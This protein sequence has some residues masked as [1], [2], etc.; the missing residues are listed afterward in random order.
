MAMFGKPLFI[1]FDNHLMTFPHAWPQME[2]LNDRGVSAFVGYRR[3]WIERKE[4]EEMNRK[5]W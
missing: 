5:R 3:E 1:R 2:L 4:G